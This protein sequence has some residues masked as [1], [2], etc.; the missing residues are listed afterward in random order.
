MRA[1]KIWVVVLL[2]APVVVTA[3]MSIRPGQYEVTLDMDLGVPKEATDAVLREGGFKGQKRLE[4]FTA[5]DV[6][7]DAW[8]MFAREAEDQNCKMSDQKTTGNR[9]TFTTTCEE[10]DVRVVTTT[11][12][13]FGPDSFSGVTKGKDDEGRTIVSKWRAKRVGDCPK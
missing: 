9:M 1:S 2:L 6:K 8:K 13:T 12:M 4:C 7:G 3:Q 5:E 10:D 11:E